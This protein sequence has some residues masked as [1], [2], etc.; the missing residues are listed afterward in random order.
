MALPSN[1]VARLSSLCA[2]SRFALAALSGIASACS[3]DSAHPSLVGAGEQPSDGGR[4]SAGGDGSD[5]AGASG[6]DNADA[7]ATNAMGG[8]GGLPLEPG[9]VG[10]Q[11]PSAPAV[12]DIAAHWSSA[13]DVAGVASGANESLLAVT[14]DELDLA[15]LRDDQVYVAHRS[16]RDAAFTVG[17]A[18]VMPSGWSASHGAALSADGKRLVLVSDPDRKMLGELT[19]ASRDSQ[20]AGD[21]DTSAFAVVNQD[22][23]FSGRIYASPT[24]S[25]GDDQLFFNSAFPDADSTVVAS[26]RNAEG[27]W[28]APRSLSA[29][30]FDGTSE[31]RRLPT[32][33]AADGRTLFY[34][35]EE[36]GDQEA[37]FRSTNSLD[38]PLYDMRSLGK[39]RG[40]T[41]N[42]ACDRLYSEADGNVVVETD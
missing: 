41:P 22:S 13:K 15:F 5:S 16:K 6:E 20:F 19:R 2:L 26:T 7:G 30:V 33:V 42:A 21:V 14:A 4:P 27:V 31:H 9:N 24:I 3:S 39:R 11:A 29:G 10:G 8:S 35:N 1:L 36:S 25:T 28:S 12:C 40:A 17:S 18:V 34:F 38:S 37:R 32:G 23:L